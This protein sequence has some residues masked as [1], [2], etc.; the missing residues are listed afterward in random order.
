MFSVCLD[1]V[2]FEFYNPTLSNGPFFF[3]WY[4]HELDH[5]N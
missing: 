4:N 3:F 5:N 1:A 2:K